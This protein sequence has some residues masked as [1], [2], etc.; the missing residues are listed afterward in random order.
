MNLLWTAFPVVSILLTVYL[1]FFEFYVPK[2]FDNSSELTI[3]YMQRKVNGS[4]ILNVC[5]H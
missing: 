1:A 3:L 2:A 5:Q 4:A